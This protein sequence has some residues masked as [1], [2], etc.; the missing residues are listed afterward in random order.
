MIGTI[1]FHQ[2]TLWNSASRDSLSEDHLHF[3]S[4]F[5]Y[6]GFLYFVPFIEFK[7]FF[8]CLSYSPHAVGFLFQGCSCKKWHC[9]KWQM[10]YSNSVLIERLA[11][12]SGECAASVLQ[13]PNAFISR[14]FPWISWGNAQSRAKNKHATC[15]VWV[16]YGWMTSDI[17][18]TW[19][20][21]IPF[22][23]LIWSSTARTS[24]GF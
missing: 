18:I 5:L 24:V 8:F 11:K 12:C 23:L 14:S 17:H 13:G 6:A 2:H 1:T 7:H 19:P 16:F 4:P 3:S 9:L 20:T 15:S 21:D 22:D 10:Y